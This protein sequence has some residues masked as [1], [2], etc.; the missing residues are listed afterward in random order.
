TIPLVV[1]LGRWMV[2]EKIPELVATPAWNEYLRLTL[3]QQ[4][5]EDAN[6]AESLDVLN[7]RISLVLKAAEANPRSHY[8]QLHAGLACL[9]QFTLKQA[10]RNHQMPLSQ[11]RDAARTLFDS[12]EDV[13]TWLNRP[14]VLGEERKLLESAIQHFQ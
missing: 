13:N 1:L 12:P 6:P 4:E 8:V 3:A 10:E 7:R 2:I 5:Q 9:K 14:G 11:I